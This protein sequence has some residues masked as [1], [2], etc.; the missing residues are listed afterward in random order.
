VARLSIEA[1]P[2]P[3]QVVHELSRE[4]VR[5]PPQ[6]TLEV[7]RYETWVVG[8]DGLWSAQLGDLQ[9]GHSRLES[10]GGREH[11]HQ[12]HAGR[13][14]RHLGYVTALAPLGQVPHQ[15]RAR[16]REVAIPQVLD[17]LQIQEFVVGIG[18]YREGTVGAERIHGPTSVEWDLVCE[19]EVYGG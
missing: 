6:K 5:R 7:L 4:V 3:C 9:D 17:V 10:V 8:K 2:P 19:E 14:C 1:N 16:R 11:Q 15:G 18:K 13:T 12:C